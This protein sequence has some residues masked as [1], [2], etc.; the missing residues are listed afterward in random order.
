MS[1]LDS[2][3]PLDP[4]VNPARGSGVTEASTSTGVQIQQ[5]ELSN[6]IQ[7]FLEERLKLTTRQAEEIIN[8]GY[9]T[10]EDLAF[11]TDDIAAD[12]T[13]IG[14][15]KVTI[16]NYSIWVQDASENGLSGEDLT[17]VDRNIIRHYVSNLDKEKVPTEIGSSQSSTESQSI[18][19]SG[20]I[21]PTDWDARERRL[22]QES[23]DL[24]R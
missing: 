17:R 24:T 16:K 4:N 21:S 9:S 12:L 15:G 13:I 3:T 14:P 22:R 23:M 18:D 6:S 10:F 8:A 20:T 11:M 5:I 19:N 1:D 7:D 2:N